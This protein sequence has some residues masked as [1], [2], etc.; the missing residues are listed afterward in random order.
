MRAYPAAAVQHFVEKPVMLVLAEETFNQLRFGLGGHF[1][2][3]VAS[4]GNGKNFR[5]T[6]LQPVPETAKPS[7]NWRI[8]K[9]AAPVDFP[10]P[11]RPGLMNK[12]DITPFSKDLAEPKPAVMTPRRLPGVPTG[13]PSSMSD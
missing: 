2:T 12:Y 9:E 6:G 7:N 3:S 1:G 4:A 5:H 8:F 13:P 11:N 10:K